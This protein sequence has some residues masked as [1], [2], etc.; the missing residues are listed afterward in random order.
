MAEVLPDRAVM[1]LTGHTR[2]ETLNRYTACRPSHWAKALEIISTVGKR[3][4]VG[5]RS[6]AFQEATVDARGPEYAI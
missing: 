6:V 5:L 3:A 1:E 2:R 4:S